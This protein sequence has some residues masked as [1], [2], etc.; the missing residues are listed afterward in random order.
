MTKFKK[1][2]EEETLSTDIAGYDTPS[3][4]K[5]F[6]R[7]M[8]DESV[9]SVTIK[10]PDDFEKI[11]QLAKQNNVEVMRPRKAIEQGDD[12]QL[13]GSKDNVNKVMLQL[14]EQDIV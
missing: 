5:T 7:N 9:I 11:Q 2:I 13:I 14:K 6:K 8:G 4:K 1:Y 12:I 3:S 10:N